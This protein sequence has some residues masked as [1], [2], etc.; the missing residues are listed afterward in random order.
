[1]YVTAVRQCVTLISPFVPS[2]MNDLE[3]LDPAYV[4]DVLSRPPFVTI[5]GVINVRDLGLY[6]STL[7]PGKS[8]KPAV[9]FRS[10]ELSGITE[11]GKHFKVH[12]LS[13][14]S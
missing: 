4:A 3:P 11:E 6:P 2:S 13:S 9:L 8:T 7:F 5:S 10:A 14:P 1:M 12:Y